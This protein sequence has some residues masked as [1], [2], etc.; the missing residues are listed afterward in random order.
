MSKRLGCMCCPLAT[1]R[2]RIIYFKEKPRMARCYLR[3]GLRF[4]NNHPDAKVR[5]RYDNVYEWFA[6]D[7]FFPREKDWQKANVS[8]FGKPD[9]KDFLE[10]QFGIEL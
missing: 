5:Q 8:L 3:A 7:V 2:K 1:E 6:R 4:W 10:K 9:W